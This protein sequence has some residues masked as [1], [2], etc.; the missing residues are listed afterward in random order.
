MDLL[1]GFLLTGVVIWIG[2]I[3]IRALFDEPITA[4]SARYFRSAENPVE[5]SLIGSIGKVVNIDSGEDDHFKVR[6]GIELWSAK[7]VSEDA[8]QP[9]VGADVRVT[10]VNGMLLDVEE[11]AAA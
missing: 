1:T 8:Q 7:L 10:A 6:I 11:H 5:S 3:V 9:S 2:Y 4:V